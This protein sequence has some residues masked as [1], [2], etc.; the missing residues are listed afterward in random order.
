MNN[1]D[2]GCLQIIRVKNRLAKGTKDI[3]INGRYTFGDKSCI[4]EIQLGVNS[5]SGKF[6]KKSFDY[7]H[8]LYEIMR[9]PFGCIDEMCRVWSKLDER[10]EWFKEKFDKMNFPDFSQGKEHNHPN[11]IMET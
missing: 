4:C 2:K 10:S 8:F 9:N 1:E 7:A 5:D 6:I 3:L 11:A